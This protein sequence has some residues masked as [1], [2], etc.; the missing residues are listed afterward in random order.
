MST[1][2]SRRSYKSVKVIVQIGMVFAIALLIFL[3]PAAQSRV[4]AQ[5]DRIHI[6]KTGESLYSIA[7]QYGVNMYTLARYN[8][9]ANVNLVQVGQVL[10]IPSASVSPTSPAPVSTPRAVSVPLNGKSAEPAPTPYI[11]DGNRPTPTPVVPTP[12]A[13]R[14]TRVHTVAAFDTLTSIANLYGTTVSAIK[15]LNGLSSDRIF[16]GQRLFI[17]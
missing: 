6:V 10:R 3:S 1:H 12:I 4:Q 9:I 11:V 15:A 16:R 5:E 14:T 13:Q 17:P 7:T 2:T 8:G